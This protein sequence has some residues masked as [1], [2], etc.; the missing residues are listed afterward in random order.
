MIQRVQSIWLFLA[1]VALLALFIFPLVTDVNIGGLKE[2]VK[3]DGVY[4]T[5]AGH[6]QRVTSFTA[7]KFTD[8]VLALLPFAIIVMYKNRKQQM[9]LCYGLIFVMIGFSAWM[10]QTVQNVIDTA[11]FKPQD[12]DFPGVLL[13]S[14]SIIFV[15]LAIR[16]I[17]N[18]ER[19]IKSA[20]RLR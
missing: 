12:Y 14:I 3:V 11:R 18:D 9:A 6:M 2:T 8:V 20:D 1:S 7:L 4:F 13:T 17:K 5:A 15:L 16:G 19:L 10:S